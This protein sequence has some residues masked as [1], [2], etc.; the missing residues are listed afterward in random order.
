MA[1]LSVFSRF[2]GIHDEDFI[3]TFPRIQ[4]E[5]NLYIELIQV[6]IGNIIFFTGIYSILCSALLDLSKASRL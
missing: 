1:I 6:N 4:V 3:V 5:Y 2:F